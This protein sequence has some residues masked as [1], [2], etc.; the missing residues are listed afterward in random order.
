MPRPG[1]LPEEVSVPDLGAEGKSVGRLGGEG[2]GDVSWRSEPPFH[3]GEGQNCEMCTVVT[4]RRAVPFREAPAYSNRRRRP[5]STLAAPR[6]LLRSNSDNNLTARPA[7]PPGANKDTLSAFEC[8]G[9][10]RKLY[11]AVPG[12]LFVV[13]KPYQPQVDG[14]IPL[15]RGDRVKVLSIGEG[16]F[17]EGSARG[18]IGWFPAECVEEVQCKPKDSQ[19]GLRRVGGA[20][21]L[22]GLRPP[23]VLAPFPLAESAL[24]GGGGSQSSLRVRDELHALMHMGTRAR[25]HMHTAAPCAPSEARTVIVATALVLGR[26]QMPVK[27]PGI[28]SWSRWPQFIA[29]QRSGSNRRVA[30]QVQSD[31]LRAGRLLHPAAELSQPGVPRCPVTRSSVGIAGVDLADLKTRAAPYTAEHWGTAREP[32]V[33]HGTTLSPTRPEWPPGTGRVGSVV[34]SGAARERCEP[35]LTKRQPQLH[36]TVPF[37]A[38]DLVLLSL[39]PESLFGWQQGPLGNLSGLEGGARP[40]EP[41]AIC[42]ISE[43]L[44]PDGRCSSIASPLNIAPED[45]WGLWS[46]L[47]Y[48]GTRS[49]GTVFGAPGALHHPIL[50]T[51]PP[52][53]DLELWFSCWV[54]RSPGN[55]PHFCCYLVR[56]CMPWAAG[57]GRVGV[58]RLLSTP[59]LDPLGAAALAKLGDDCSLGSVPP[60]LTRHTCGPHTGVTGLAQPR[61]CWGP[62]PSLREGA[63]KEGPEHQG[64]FSLGAWQDQCTPATLTACDVDLFADVQWTVEIR[65]T[66][67]DRSKKLFRHYTVGSYDSFDASSSSRE[68]EQLCPPRDARC[69]GGAASALVHTLSPSLSDCPGDL[70]LIHCQASVFPPFADFDPSAT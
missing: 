64:T 29:A 26:T 32:W 4:C 18:H 38:F 31:P 48:S 49:R 36:A 1:R 62:P 30:S 56:V 5:P 11:S 21:S 67:A 6:V 14:E 54:P 63:G 44:A 19:A 40:L 24:G 12:R 70:L 50:P 33:G 43:E 59:E 53:G 60:L 16:G 22:P 28:S 3:L 13:V 27:A 9:P 66:R 52:C 37:P 47:G 45:L 10:R 35:I 34:H 61:D 41:R 57:P 20:S 39:G 17:W 51:S 65:E 69:P 68:S 58:H 8:P 25:T 23:C 2:T 42:M 55:W 46:I 15:H 7:F